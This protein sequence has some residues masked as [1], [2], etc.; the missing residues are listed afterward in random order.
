MKKMKIT[1]ENEYNIK[2]IKK[3]FVSNVFDLHLSS[4][5]LLILHKLNTKEKAKTVHVIKL[6]YYIPY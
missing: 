4:H 1:N 5:L 6:T 3:L 2:T